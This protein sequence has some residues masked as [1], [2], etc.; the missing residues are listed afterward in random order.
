M[1][2]IYKSDLT[3]KNTLPDFKFE[4]YSRN[5]EINFSGHQKLISSA[6][7]DYFGDANA[8]NPEEILIGALS[9]CH[10]LTFLAIAS[11]S[12]YN[13]ESYNSTAVAILGKNEEGKMSVTDIELTPQVVFRG[14][15]IPSAEGLMGLHD[16]A[17]RNCFIAQSIKA[18]VSIKNI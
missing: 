12:G 4:T 7:P 3:W 16:K 8:A 13:I 5:H 9:S 1:S 2:A 11:K 14:E 6:S 18:K 17:H 10:M 15:K